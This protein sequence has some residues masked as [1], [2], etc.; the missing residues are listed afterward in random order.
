M[1]CS[2]DAMSPAARLQAGHANY[3]SGRWT[4]AV[5]EYRHLLRF[6]PQH[7]FARWGLADA[8]TQIHRPYEAVAV[9]QEG[10]SMARAD[11]PPLLMIALSRIQAMIASS[12]TR[13]DRCQEAQE[14]IQDPVLLAELYG[15]R[16]EM[17]K[18][19][20]LLEEAADTK[21]YRLSAVNMFPQFEQI[22]ADQRYDRL[23]ERIGLH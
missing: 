7:M 16:G 9:L 6:T 17:A 2:L 15:S 23:L 18:A 8:L 3:A 20:K 21:H 14:A 12:P 5:T 22:R 1:A 11:S 13:Q 10:L 4:A 19:F